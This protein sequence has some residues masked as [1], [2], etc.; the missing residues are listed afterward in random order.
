MSARRK[1][2]VVTGGAGFIGSNILADLEA[3]ASHEL[4][5]CDRLGT[6]DKWRNL[7]KREL[8]DIVRPEA[9]FDFLAAEAGR[10]EA[11]VHM[12]ACTSTTERNADLILESNIRLSV[13]L[14]NWCTAQGVRFIYASSAATYGDGAQGFDDD[15]SPE[16]LAR[17]R[18]LNAYGW[19]KHLVDRRVARVVAESGERPPQWAGLKFFNV[20]GANEY[21]KGEMRSV[22]AKKYELIAQGKPVTLFKSH[23][24]E[25]PDGGQKRDF[26]SVDDAV[27]VVLWLIERPEISGLFNVGTGRACSFRELFDAAFEAAGIPPAI[28]YIDMPAEL[29]GRYQYFTQADLRR[30]RAVGFTRPFTPAPEAVRRYVADYLSRSDPYR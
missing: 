14:W 8:T 29:R 27:A 7:A 6:E 13:D 3:R 30:L 11:I 22:I 21:H 20:F 25:Y 1:S 19:S 10:I 26:V 17:L 5:V 15:P 2:I 16:A 24:P 18:P 4:V 9:L 12:G 28:K 23:R